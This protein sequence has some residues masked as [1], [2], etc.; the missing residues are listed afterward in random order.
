MI[1]PIIREDKKTKLLMEYIPEPNYVVGIDPYDTTKE[2]SSFSIS[3]TKPELYKEELELKP[4]IRKE[5]SSITKEK[6]EP[7]H[8]TRYFILDDKTYVDVR[9]VSNVNGDLELFCMGYKEVYG[10][11]RQ[12]YREKV[13]M[14][15]AA[16][17]EYIESVLKRFALKAIQL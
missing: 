3:S 9:V 5:L 16:Y 8:I 11:P 17:N 4:L 7:T 14:T 12:F 10:E 15:I 6:F 1:Y 13:V 2:S